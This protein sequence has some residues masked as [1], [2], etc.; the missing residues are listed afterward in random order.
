MKGNLQPNLIK[1]QQKNQLRN[2]GLSILL[3]L[4]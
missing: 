1:Q 4:E 3:I 2:N